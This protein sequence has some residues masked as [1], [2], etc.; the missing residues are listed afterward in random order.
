MF[1]LISLPI[2]FLAGANQVVLVTLLS[3]STL[4]LLRTGI[5]KDFL[6]GVLWFIF[7]TILFYYAIRFDFLPSR[8]NE[9]FLTGFEIKFS[10]L[11]LIFLEQSFA[12]RLLG[13]GPGQT[14]SRLAFESISYKDILQNFGFVYSSLAEDFYN[15]E[16]YIN[17]RYI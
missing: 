15:I 3:W 8:S 16:R 10:V 14:I 6:K 17:I 7:G 9:E 11:K 1:A 12:Q 4:L 13:L 5:S 2:I